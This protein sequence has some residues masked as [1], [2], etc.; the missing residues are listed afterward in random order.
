MH[1]PLAALL[2]IAEEKMKTGELSLTKSPTKLRVLGAWLVVVLTAGNERVCL[3]WEAACRG[4]RE[5]WLLPS[6]SW[7]VSGRLR[8]LLLGCEVSF[9]PGLCSSVSHQAE[10]K[11]PFSPLEWTLPFW[12]T[13]QGWWDSTW[14]AESRYYVGT[15]MFWISWEDRTVKDHVWGGR[16]SPRADTVW[17]AFTH[18]LEKSSTLSEPIFMTI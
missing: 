14:W 3:W 16:M 1:T 4:N 17:S 13:L 12:G 11:S 9:R 2:M 7:H 10:W 18:P 15:S 5:P 6:G 8:L